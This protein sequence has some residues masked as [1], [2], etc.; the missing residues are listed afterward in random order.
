[1]TGFDTEEEMLQVYLKESAQVET[2]DNLIDI[3]LATS[4]VLAGI[5]FQ[6]EI[7]KGVIPQHLEVSKT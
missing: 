5:V 1:M 7:T 4:S 3:L 2:E 6:G